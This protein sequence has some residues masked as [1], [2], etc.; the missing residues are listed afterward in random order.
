MW[1]RISGFS[2]VRDVSDLRSV[3]RVAGVLDGVYCWPEG[4]RHYVHVHGVVLPR[5][6]IDHVLARSV[7]LTDAQV[8]EDW[9][10]QAAIID[11]YGTDGSGDPYSVFE[12]QKRTVVRGGTVA[13]WAD[14]GGGGVQY[15][16]PASVQDLLDAGYLSRVGQ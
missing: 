7:A 11:R 15:K 13:P 5:E 4:L 16:L 14:S 12:V 2:G 8:D 6:F 1:V 3:K 10:V 9:W